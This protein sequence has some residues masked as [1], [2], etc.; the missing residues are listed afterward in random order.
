A[1]NVVSLVMFVPSAVIMLK[2]IF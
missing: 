1:V 2:P